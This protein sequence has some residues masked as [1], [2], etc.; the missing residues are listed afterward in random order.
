MRSEHLLARI[1]D[2]NLRAA[3]KK[4]FDVAERFAAR[5]QSLANN[6][7]LS[8]QGRFESI[9]TDLKREFGPA[10]RLARQPL[11]EA[12]AAVDVR[13]AKISLPAIDPTDVVAQLQRME[14]RASVAALDP[15]ERTKLLFES[16][17]DVRIIDAVIAEPP[18]LSGLPRDRHAELLNRRLQQ[19]FGPDIAALED[20]EQALAEAEA[21]IEVAKHHMKTSFD[22]DQKSD[23]RQFDK[24]MEQATI[25]WLVD[26][27]AFITVVK[28]G[29]DGL[30]TYPPATELEKQTGK[31]FK[32]VEEYNAQ[33]A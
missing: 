16:G 5:R 20:E 3:V 27:G 17:T 30:A 26:S 9:A 33:A 22:P 1:G 15:V 31:F 21:A 7:S 18:E 25:P 8:D 10:F 23:R 2:E 14:R 13:K 12:R 19:L 28:I 6:P 11:R 4:A 29:A 24:I 32:N